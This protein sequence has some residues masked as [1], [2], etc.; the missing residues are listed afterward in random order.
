MRS[1]T[2]RIYENIC[3]EDIYEGFYDNI[4]PFDNTPVPVVYY[5]L[6]EWNDYAPEKTDFISNRI[7]TT[8]SK[9]ASLFGIDELSNLILKIDPQPRFNK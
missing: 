7:H 3:E 8:I 9:S 4:T 1:I 6:N 2:E 5:T